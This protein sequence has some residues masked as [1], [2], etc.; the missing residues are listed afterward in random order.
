MVRALLPS[1][2]VCF[3]GRDAQVVEEQEKEHYQDGHEAL[4]VVC[5]VREE[6][7]VTRLVQVRKEEEEG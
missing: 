3:T 7:H 4:G 2:R 1:H 6:G 5:D